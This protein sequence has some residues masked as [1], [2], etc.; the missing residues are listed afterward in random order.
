MTGL[1]GRLAAG[2]LV[3]RAADPADGRG[4]LV[5]V[6]EDGRAVLAARRQARAA[7]LATLLDDLDADDHA[8]LAAAMGAITRLVTKGLHA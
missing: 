8:A 3:E 4:V 6:T 2:G 7:A 5:S 1:V